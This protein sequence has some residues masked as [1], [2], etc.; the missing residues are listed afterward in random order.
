MKDK[1]ITFLHFDYA[2]EIIK[3]LGFNNLID[4]DK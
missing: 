2:N 1:T 4:Y 3:I